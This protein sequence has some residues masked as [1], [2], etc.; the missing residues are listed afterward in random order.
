MIP[1]KNKR[2]HRIQ[3]SENFIFL[4]RLIKNPRSLGAIAPSSKQLARF[5]CNHIHYNEADYLV[6]IG[7]GTGRFTRALLQFGVPASRLIVIELDPELAQYLRMN[8]PAVT[9]I[10]GDATLLASL[11]PLETKGRVRTIISGIPMVNLPKK[12]QK[13]IMDACFDVLDENGSV[14]QFTYGLI[15][16]ISVK[17]FGLHGEKLGRVMQNIPPATIWRYSK[18][19]FPQSHKEKSTRTLKKF[20]RNFQD[21]I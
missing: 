18:V 17:D 7:A 11:L 14:L 3:N 21:R 13:G 16:P 8:F 5:I 2:F 1:P 4:K 19:P 12:I 9:V 15:S 20:L 6:E 10:Q